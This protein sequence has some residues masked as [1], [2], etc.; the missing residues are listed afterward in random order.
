[1]K[2]TLSYLLF[3][4][5]YNTL[6]LKTKQQ[7]NSI[8]CTG[9]DNIVRNNFQTLTYYVT[10]PRNILIFFKVHYWN[11]H[12]KCPIASMKWFKFK[13]KCV[14]YFLVS[15]I[16]FKICRRQWN[17]EAKTYYNVIGFRHLSCTMASNNTFIKLGRGGNINGHE[18]QYRSLFIMFHFRTKHN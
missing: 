17:Y 16:W 10:N 7:N 1:M 6:M 15:E 18:T 12:H 3:C 14:L 2:V 8:S 9:N 13:T 4:V 5:F 11:K